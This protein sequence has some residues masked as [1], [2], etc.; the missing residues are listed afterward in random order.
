MMKY[1]SLSITITLY[2]TTSNYLLIFISTMTPNVPH[3]WLLF[4]WF[5]C[6]VLPYCLR[7]DSCLL[8]WANTT[9]PL[10][11]PSWELP[12]ISPLLLL[13]AQSTEC[14][15]CRRPATAPLCTV[16]HLEH[17]SANFTHGGANGKNFRLSRPHLISTVFFPYILIMW[18]P[19]LAHR[20]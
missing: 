17:R 18:K 5:A 20:P 3:S 11:Q 13:C 15:L 8:S 2:N 19:L 4:S 1:I 16:T 6:K 12:A 9:A 10:L 14:R 7:W